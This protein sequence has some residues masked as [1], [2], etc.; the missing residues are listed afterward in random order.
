[1]MQLTPIKSV[2]TA[3][4]P[5]F[6]IVC[7][8]SFRGGTPARPGD[9]TDLP[10]PDFTLCCMSVNLISVRSYG[11]LRQ[12]AYRTAV[13]PAER[14]L[15]RRPRAD[16]RRHVTAAAAV[17]DDR[18]RVTVTVTAPV[19]CRGPGRR[20]ARSWRPAGAG[21]GPAGDSASQP[22]P[23]RRRRTRDHGMPPL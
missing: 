8:E 2:T 3:I 6:C 21:G 1:M 14:P 5:N 4:K 7:E 9:V 17:N 10:D 13:G 19:L 11:R 12:L 23:P 20:R 22:V 15:P 16:G 18:V